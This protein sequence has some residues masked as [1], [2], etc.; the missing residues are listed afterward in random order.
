M[1]LKLPFAISFS[2]FILYIY[3]YIYM[4]IYM[5]M[6][7]ICILINLERNVNAI[8]GLILV[9]RAEKNF[10]KFKLKPKLRLVPLVFLRVMVVETTGVASIFRYKF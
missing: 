5:Y 3:I 1:F 4:F 6:Y 7:M 2:V 8:K 9:T 10:K